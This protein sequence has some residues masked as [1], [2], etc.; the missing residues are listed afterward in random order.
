MLSYTG[1][2]H[3]LVL[4]LED[5]D[6]V[7]L[8]NVDQLSTCRMK[9]YPDD[10]T[11]KLRLFKKMLYTIRRR[12]PLLFMAFPEQITNHYKVGIV[13]WVMYS[14]ISSVTCR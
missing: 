12:I 6:Y 10:V 9:L 13:L 3:G 14:N 2:L 4:N 11:L 5:G 1:F 7:F 8:R